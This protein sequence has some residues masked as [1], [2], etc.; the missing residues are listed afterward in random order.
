MKV[1]DALDNPNL[2]HFHNESITTAFK[3]AVAEMI[4]HIQVYNFL[5]IFPNDWI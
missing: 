2:V 5:Y 3:K 1:S 4:L